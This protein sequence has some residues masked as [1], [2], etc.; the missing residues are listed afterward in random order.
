MQIACSTI[1]YMNHQWPEILDVIAR[2][3]WKNVE[4]VAIPGWM[5]VDIVQTGAKDI[6]SEMEKRGLRLQALHTGALSGAGPLGPIYEL[7]YMRGAVNVLEQAGA[8]QLV[9]TGGPRERSKLEDLVAALEQLAP[10]LD[11]ASVKLGLENHYTNRIETIEDYDFIFSK[12]D[13]PQIGVTA[14]FGHFHSSGVDTAALLRKFA[15]KLF[16]VHIKDHVGTVSMPFGQGDV[17]IPSLLRILKEIGYGRAISAEL[18]VEDRENLDQYA[19]EARV[20][21]NKLNDEL[22]A[23]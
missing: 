18:E 23:G 8:D 21:L 19:A 1:C 17:D 13:H 15:D 7:S 22:A 9:F 4:L 12:I 16:H 3:G 6:V 10:D 11:R 14:D 20:Y 5:H 2:H